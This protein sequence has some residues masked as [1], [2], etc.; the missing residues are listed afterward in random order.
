MCFVND[1]WGDRFTVSV[2]GIVKIVKRFGRTILVHVGHFRQHGRW[3]RCAVSTVKPR[4][5]NK[6]FIIRFPF[7]T[8]AV[9]K[10]I[11]VFVY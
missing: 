7:P 9:M 10:T 3:L 8:F 11:M 2:F 5:G 1:N 4:C 6:R